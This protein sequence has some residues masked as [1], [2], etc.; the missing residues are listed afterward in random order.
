MGTPQQHVQQAQHN[1]Q[2]LL[3]FDVRRPPYLDWLVTVLFYAA[4]HYLRAL[5]SRHG[6]SN[7]SRYGEVDNAFSRLLIFR[8]NAEV[9]IDYRQLKDDSRRAR[10]EFWRPGV[11]E[12]E[13]LR[14]QELARIRAF[15]MQ[16]V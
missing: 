15:V 7:I 16:R 11:R 3:Q 1:E 2:F 13:E 5:L 6:L 14:D 10:Y 9:Y 4:L 8:R 12:V